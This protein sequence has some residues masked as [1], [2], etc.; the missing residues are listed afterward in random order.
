MK[1]LTNL[2]TSVK[3]SY[4][5]NLIFGLLH[6]LLFFGICII[7]LPEILFIFGPQ[8]IYQKVFELKIDRTYKYLLLFA[9]YITLGFI[10]YF[11][12]IIVKSYIF[13]ILFPH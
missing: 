7:F 1:F 2:V 3:N 10:I 11:T 13:P 9:S 6:T 4:K 5:K 8:L 12:F